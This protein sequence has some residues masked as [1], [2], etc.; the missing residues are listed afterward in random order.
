[1]NESAFKEMRVSATYVRILAREYYDPPGILAALGVS[2]ATASDSETVSIDDLLT[3]VRAIDGDHRDRGWHLE[4]ARRT[5]DHFHGPL[6]YALMS[7]PTIGDG[8]YAF[9]RYLQ[10][11]APYFRGTHHRTG[12]KVSIEI[13]ELRNLEDIRHLLVEIPFRI[14]HDYVAM[15]GAV[16]LAAATL[17]L[18]YPAA[19][20]RDYYESGFDCRVLFE[21]QSNA[22]TMPAAWMVIPNPQYD[23]SAWSSATARC[24][25]AL[26]EL[27]PANTV[28]RVRAYINSTLAREPRD[29]SINDAARTLGVSV[30]T[31]IRRLRKSGSSFQTLRDSARQDLAVHLLGKPNLTVEDVAV[32]LGFSDAANFSRA[33]KRWFGASPRRYRRQR[34]G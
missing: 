17:S 19:K 34:G 1:V 14:L 3:L 23:E 32:A 33:F 5:A 30:R 8:L 11:R 2:D 9:A 28:G 26:S 7:A 6:T 10:I 4:V 15:I 21:Q 20:R 22:L 12:P 18:Q 31:L 29:L 25:V 24:E 27:T 16:D 13:E